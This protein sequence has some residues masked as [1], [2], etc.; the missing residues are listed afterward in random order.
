[1]KI[2]TCWLLKD[3]ITD[4][5]EVYTIRLSRSMPLGKKTTLKPL[6]GCT[7]TISDDMG[8]TYTA[9]ESSTSGTY[10]TTPGIFQGVVGRE[11]TLHIN[12]NN[13][14]INHYSYESTAD[15]DAGCSPDRQSLL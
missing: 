15:G 14:T 2:P 4:Q 9:P 6:K 12:T 11:Y 7:V 5:P 1:M 13:S 3:L 10:L 8:H